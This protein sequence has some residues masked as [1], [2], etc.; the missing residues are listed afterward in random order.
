MEVNV[1]DSP[2]GMK[3]GLHT[4]AGTTRLLGFSARIYKTSAIQSV[5]LSYYLPSVSC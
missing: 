5:Y 2:L 4:F 3:E 1:C